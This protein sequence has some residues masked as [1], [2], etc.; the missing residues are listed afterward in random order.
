[1][2]IESRSA[3]LRDLT[4]IRK[5]EIQG[6]YVANESHLD[7]RFLRSNANHDMQNISSPPRK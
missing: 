6:G 7:N 2:S 1:M 4:W 3:N 5:P